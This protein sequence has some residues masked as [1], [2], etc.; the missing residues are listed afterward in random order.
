M[1]SQWE[2]EWN[3]VQTSVL[4]PELYKGPFGGTR[5]QLKSKGGRAFAVVHPTLWNALPPPLEK[6]CVS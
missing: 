3:E 2:K 4:P 1:G 6:H 5:D